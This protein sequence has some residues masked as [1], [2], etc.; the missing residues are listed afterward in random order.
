[1]GRA[2][3]TVAYVTTPKN[4]EGGRPAD[5][6][7]AQLS[8][9]QKLTPAELA[10]LAYFRSE[11]CVACHLGPGKKGTGP[12]LTQMPANHRSAAWLVK[13]FKE[14]AEVV[15]GSAVLSRAFA[16]FRIELA[17][18]VRNEAHAG[19][20]EADLLEAPASAQAV[21][22]AQIYTDNHCTACH[23]LAGSGMKVGP[24]LDGVG[25]RHDRAW[26]EEHFKNPSAVSP[27]QQNACV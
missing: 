7:S 14:P 12:D 19:Q 4:P 13:H 11:N 25:D 17:G 26:L 22:G 18:S 21:R 8:D 20:S 16:R 27:G 23:Q 9:W 24:A 6:N 5:F 15:P 2:L 3:T 1:M 10:G